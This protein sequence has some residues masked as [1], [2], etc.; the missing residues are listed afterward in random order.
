MLHFKHGGI[1]L[2]AGLGFQVL[3]FATVCLL[4]EYGG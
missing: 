4:M 2:A 1:V 3:D